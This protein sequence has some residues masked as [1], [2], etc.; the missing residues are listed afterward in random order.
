MNLSNSSP[1]ILESKPASNSVVNTAGSAFTNSIATFNSYNFDRNLLTPASAF[2]F[3]A[4]GIDKSVRQSIRSGDMVGLYAV[5]ETDG[6]KW[7][8]ATGFVDET[9]THIV[10]GNVEYV[11]TGRD[12]LAQLVDNASVD[13]LNKIQNTTNITL[14]NFMK[15][16]LAN[17]RIPQGFI[18]QDLPNGPLLVNT[19]PG[20]TKINSLQRYLDFMNCLVWTNAQ[21]QIVVGRPNFSQL[22]AGS[23]VMNSSATKNNNL[24]EARVRRNTNTAIRQIVTQL[25]TLGQTDAGFYTVRNQDVDMQKVSG[26][27]VGRSVYQLFSY[28]S[29]NDTLNQITQVGNQNASPQNLGASLSRREIAKDNVKVIEVEAVVRGHFNE[30]GIPYNIDQIY[31]VQIEDDSVS[32]PMYVYGV[33]YE[34]TMEHGVLTRL[35]LCRVGTTLVDGAG[36]TKSISVSDNVGQV[37]TGTA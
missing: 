15:Q 5:S 13:A 37:S 16:L 33:S 3:T 26:Y 7:Q 14:T 30:Q 22:P 12:T 21:G 6:T 4:P 36:I 24:L 28:G 9:D 8:I 32:E 34:L 23:L 10:P 35:K 29:G 1:V 2:R 20:E 19:N 25:Q 27:K 17:T 18:G 11:L 31:D